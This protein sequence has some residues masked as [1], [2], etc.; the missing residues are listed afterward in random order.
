MKT[1]DTHRG[2]RLALVDDADDWESLDSDP[3]Y[4]S[5]DH[6]PPLS[7]EA[8]PQVY[9]K[10]MHHGATLDLQVHDRMGLNGE[11]PPKHGWTKWRGL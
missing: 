8:I 4:V 11:Q 2:Q 1:F 10:Q 6:A 9:L 3:R 7:D 5:L